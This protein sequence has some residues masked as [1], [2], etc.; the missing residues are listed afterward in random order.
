MIKG[1]CE[2]GNTRF[3]MG[4]SE[5]DSSSLKFKTNWGA[6]VVELNYNYYLR[7]LTDVPYAD[8]RNPRYKLP[9]AIWK[10]LPLPVTGVLGPWL[11]R[12][13]A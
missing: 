3:D 13:I 11:I 4:R 10:K 9:I 2:R 12:G 7:T 1:S 8:P 5:A 6:Q